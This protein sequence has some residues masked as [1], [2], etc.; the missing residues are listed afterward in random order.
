MKKT[1][2]CLSVLL[3]YP[4]DELKAGT[5]DIQAALLA[6]GALPAEAVQVL[7]PLLQRLAG[8]D[9]MELQ[10][11]YSEL[12]DGSR[13]L[14]LHLFEHVHGESRE[15]GQA[16][17]DLTQ[18]YTDHGYLIA[19]NELAD[20]L[21]LFLEF[22][23]LLEPSQARDWLA[24]PAH[25]FAAL[26]ERLVQRAS[27]YAAVLHALQVLPK[28]RVDPDALA[29]L[30]ARFAAEDAKSIDEAWQEAPV[31]FASAGPA[32]SAA[33]GGVVERIRAALRR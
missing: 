20:F 8:E 27:P 28:V 15:R 18:Q 10:C 7:Q 12:F 9:L 24:R 22:V 32:G 11:E 21:P 2:K 5:R 30:R 6:E 31:S 13:P 3:G 33:D 1:L 23:S 4:S 26:E 25:V 14:S 16:L 29:A 19:N 17:I